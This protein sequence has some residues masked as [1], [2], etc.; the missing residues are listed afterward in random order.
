MSLSLLLQADLITLARLHGLHCWQANTI[1]IPLA[2]AHVASAGSFI[3]TMYY[4]TQKS[5]FVHAFKVTKKLCMHTCM[6][7][8]HTIEYAY[9]RTIDPMIHGCTVVHAD[10]MH[11]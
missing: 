10:V 3:V 7:H 11:L 9:E 2:E 4:T 5:A 1:T 6:W 8:N